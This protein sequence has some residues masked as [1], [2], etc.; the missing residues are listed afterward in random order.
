[1][2][3]DRL[4][5]KEDPDIII[6]YNTFG[7]DYKFIYDRS[8]ELNIDLHISRL[9]NHI[10]ELKE[11]KLSSAALGEN[12]MNV[13]SCEGRINIDLYKVMQSQHQLDSYKLDNVCLKFLNKE[14]MDLSPKDIFIKQRGTSA[15]RKEIAKYCLID[16]ILCNRLLIKLE[17]FGNAL[18]M[19]NVC[20]VPVSYIFSR[21][22]GPKIASLTSFECFKQGY[23]IPSD[24][25]ENADDTGYE[26][27]IVLPPIRGIHD[28]PVVVLDFNS[29]Y[30]N[31]MISENLSHDTFVEIGGK[32]D[33]LE[34]Y[35]YNNVTYDDY[36]YVKQKSTKS[37]IIKLVKTKVGQCTCRYV[38][39][40]G[41][42]TKMGCIPYILDFLLTQRKIAKKKMEQETDE[43]KIKLY[44]GLQL[45][46]KTVANSI[47]GQIG[48]P[49]SIILKKQIAASTTAIG[50]L[51]ITT[52][53]DHVINQYADRIVTLLEKDSIDDLTG[54]VTQYAGMKIH[55]KNG[56]CV[57]GDTDSV[58]IKLSIEKIDDANVANVANVGANV[59]NVGANTT[60]SIEDKIRI[61]IILGKMIANEVTG[62]LKRPQKLAFEK[63]LVDFFMLNMKKYMALYYT[64]LSMADDYIKMGEFKSMGIVLR[65]RDNSPIVKHIY[66][67]TV[68]CII[69]GR[70]KGLKDEAIDIAFEY[71]MK[72]CKKVLNNQFPI[73][74]FIIS[75]NLKSY[76]KF[77]K[78]IAHN[79]LAQRCAKRDKGNC[80]QSNDR[81]PYVYI[82]ITDDMQREING[83]V[84]Q[85]NRIDTP[86]YIMQYGKQIDYEF[87]ITNQIMEPICQIFELVYKYRNISREFTKLINRHNEELRGTRFTDDIFTKCT[88]QFFSIKDIKENYRQEIEVI[89]VLAEPEQHSY[90]PVDDLNN[91]ITLIN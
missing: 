49:T 33:N 15:D 5:I 27:A 26:G 65:R 84:L 83:D 53:R 36:I 1:M 82:K 40:A 11:I 72:E 12:T 43:F 77:P 56:H 69:D 79:V 47:Y 58:F 71:L 68:K 74:M 32:Y 55:I 76:Y 81:V 8:R 34:G 57:Y 80:F 6:G 23:L 63:V 4:V 22:Q 14:K 66:S 9:K 13:I 59:A 62:L 46:Y 91:M 86:Q 75:K 78:R 28:D 87:Y 16:C 88:K 50:R 61:M 29:L 41:K 90:E 20:K 70:R 51:M 37:K 54:Q 44:N 64:V 17:I 42:N 39:V 25:N 60:L 35:E 19:A 89:N 48:S 2:E 45:A 85:G 10:S 67:N 3:W 52:T 7:F 21:G 38:K 31:S 30:P 24:K 73:E 18:A